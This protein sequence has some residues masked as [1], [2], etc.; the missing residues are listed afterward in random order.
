MQLPANLANLIRKE[1]WY[2]DGNLVVLTSDNVAFRV[3]RCV[4]ARQSEVFASMDA[5]P[6]PPNS[7]ML[8]RWAY[9]AQRK[10]QPTMDM[11]GANLSRVIGKFVS[12]RMFEG[13][14]T[15]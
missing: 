10:H 4:L 12:R 1:P 15:N 7:F 5:I 2:R 3:H 8:F 11:S 14:E 6:R 9:V 13:Q